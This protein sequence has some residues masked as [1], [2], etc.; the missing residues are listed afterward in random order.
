MQVIANVLM[1]LLLRATAPSPVTT[2]SNCPVAQVSGAEQQQLVAAIARH[3]PSAGAITSKPETVERE[4][5]LVGTVCHQVAVLSWDGG[6]SG[7]VAVFTIQQPSGL[8]IVFADW[9]R[10]ANRLTML[11]RG[12]ILFAWRSGWGS[13]FL[14]E[15][16]VVLQPLAGTWQRTHYFLVTLVAAPSQRG[17]SQIGEQLS[18][19]TTYSARGDTLLIARIDSIGE[20]PSAALRIRRTLSRFVLP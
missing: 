17:N 11:P 7:G 4:S 3:A 20:A 19:H 12:S 2:S 5:M 15:Q 1:V 9:Y 10:G 18:V 16:A 6:H 8:R 14:E 13:G